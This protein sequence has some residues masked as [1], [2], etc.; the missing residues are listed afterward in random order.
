LFTFGHHK[1][2]LTSA[3]YFLPSLTES[4]HVRLELSTDFRV[5]LFS[6]FYW[7]LNLFESFDND[8]PPGGADN[9]FEVSTSLGWTF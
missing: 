4:G 8:P 3:L 7:S 2:N 9:D 6:D 1:T 5:E